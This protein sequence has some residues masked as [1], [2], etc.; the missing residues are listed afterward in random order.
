M[1]GNVSWSSPPLTFATGAPATSSCKVKFTDV[2]NWGN[3]YVASV[4]ITNT[5]PSALDSWT[6]A[7]NWPTGWQRMDGGWNAN[8]SQ[9][10]RTVKAT[11][12]SDNG[13]LAAGASWN[14]GFV[15]AYSGPNILPTAFTL[16]GTLCSIE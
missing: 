14:M 10:G 15:A 5:S 7:Y 8:W 3:G 13:K 4:D 16:N 9:E 2:T 12:L 1:A 6:L 11:S